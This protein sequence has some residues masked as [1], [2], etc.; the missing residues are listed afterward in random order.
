MEIWEYIGWKIIRVEN[1]LVIWDFSLHSSIQQGWVES[2]NLYPSCN[3]RKASFYRYY[4]EGIIGNVAIIWK[5]IISIDSASDSFSLIFFHYHRTF[6]QFDIENLSQKG[7]L[8]PPFF[9]SLSKM[10]VF[11]LNMNIPKSHFST[12]LISF[13][14]CCNIKQISLFIPSPVVLQSSDTWAAAYMDINIFVC[15]WRSHEVS[16]SGDNLEKKSH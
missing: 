2:I 8:S 3:N 10:F 12:S 4:C 11:I 1:W 16:F 15:N 6:W 5:S 9:S 7:L 14:T 13:S